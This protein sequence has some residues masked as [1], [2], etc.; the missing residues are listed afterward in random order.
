MLNLVAMKKVF[1]D[2]IAIFK[3]DHSKLL[4]ENYH[5][6]TDQELKDQITKN[7]ILNGICVD[8]ALYCRMK[9]NEVGIP[10]TLVLCMTETK[11]LHLVCNVHGYIFD[12]RQT[13]FCTNTELESTGYNFLEE[14]G[15][16]VG[17][18]WFIIEK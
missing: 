13:I 14:S 15:E 11:E 1:Y 16:H 5:W 10:N 18:K 8:F 4:P 3:Y 7:G 17:D 6:D 2:A 9:L 12:N